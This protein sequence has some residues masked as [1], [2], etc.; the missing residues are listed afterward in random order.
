MNW[1]IA[2]RESGSPELLESPQTSP[3]VPRT[4]PEVPWRLPGSSL[5]V[6]FNSLQRFSGSFLPELVQ[7]SPEVS[8]FLWEAWHL[9]LTHQNF[10]GFPSFTQIPGYLTKKICFSLSFEGHTR[11]FWLPPFTLGFSIPSKWTRRV[12]VANCCWP[13]VATPETSEK[14]TVGTVTASHDWGKAF[15]VTSD[16]LSA[17]TV[18]SIYTPLRF[19]GGVRC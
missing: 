14:Q 19:E 13:L 2:G 15:W 6:E 17:R 3:E 12:W 5:T 7:T 9:L 4:Y 18:A 10:L 1:R 16:S 8:P 11:T